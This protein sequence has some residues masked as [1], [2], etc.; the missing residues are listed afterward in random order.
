MDIRRPERKVKGGKSSMRC[1]MDAE[2]RWN[3]GERREKGYRTSRFCE[4]ILDE[5]TGLWRKLSEECVGDVPGVVFC[6]VAA[7]EM[8]DE[9]AERGREGGEGKKGR[10]G[11]RKRMWKEFKKL[12][13]RG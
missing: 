2:G 4:V 3:D 10:K 7:P 1:F 6:G 5:E 8:G 12:G 9:A 13:R 11:W